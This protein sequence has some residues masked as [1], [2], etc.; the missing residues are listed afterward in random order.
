MV[1]W[2]NKR[3]SKSLVLELRDDIRF[4]LSKLRWEQLIK[5]NSDL[6]AERPQEGT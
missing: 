2:V 1:I 5:K 6:V 4:T 3:L